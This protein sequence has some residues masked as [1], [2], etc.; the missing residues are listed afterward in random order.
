MY[1]KEI[2]VLQYK[3]NLVFPSKI[4]Y[5]CKTTLWT[6]GVEDYLFME[7]ARYN[8]Y[9]YQCTV[10]VCGNFTGGFMSCIL[11]FEFSPVML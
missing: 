6:V 10:H 8:C 4:L 11:T 3:N 2:I 1:V 5:F 9:I 7:I